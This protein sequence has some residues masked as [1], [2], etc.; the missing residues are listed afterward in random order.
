M[1]AP[2]NS[3]SATG[4]LSGPRDRRT[5][6]LPF[7]H[8][9]RRRATEPSPELADPTRSPT[10]RSGAN[11]WGRRFARYLA[12]AD[13]LAIVL[14]A[15]AVQV[16]RFDGVADVSL[17]ARA[18]FVPAV[19][20]SFTLGVA[21]FI[22]LTVSGSRHRVVI[23]H[24]PNE[25]KAVVRS[26]LWLFGAL[27]IVSYVFQLDLPRSYVAIMMP[28]GA[29]L[30]L[31]SRYLWRRWL[32]G[33]RDFGHFQS[34]VLAVGSVA[35]VCEL[36]TELKDS[37]RAGYR[38][39]GACLTELPDEPVLE[40]AGIPIIGTVDDIKGAVTQVQ[41]DAVAITAAAGLSPATVRSLSWQLEDSDTNLILAPALTD[42]AGTRIHRQPVNGLSLIHVERPTYRGANRW[43]K[44]SFDYVGAA[45]LVL[46]F[47]VPMAVIAGL[48]K[49][50]DRGPVFFLQE[51]VGRDG[52]TFRVVKFRSM[53]IDAEARLA[54]LKAAQTQDAGN[55]VLFKLKDD[56]RITT[57][58]KFLRKFSLD[59]LPQLFNVLGGSMSLVGPRPPLA[60][61]VAQYCSAAHRRL[62]VRPGMT[63]LWQVSGRSSLD[64][65]ETVRL[66]SYYV[67]NWSIT[68][69]LLILWKTMRAV[70]SGG[71]AY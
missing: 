7:T 25:Y 52:K 61:E 42:I 39:V 64:W 16:I 26:T 45:L 43:L 35:S 11:V 17:G 15:A 24:G 32:Q 48:I 30:L 53:V 37:Q 23:G 1:S 67:E 44:K 63:G 66:D 27:A 19:L 29:M 3:E 14:A 10:V 8:P 68:G 36:V 5:A 56:P 58:G 60:S 41:A 49:L 65:D 20:V 4:F 62:L 54:E 13:A 71:G 57:I 38:V 50:T 55:G 34:A 12:V 6:D 22:G 47:A 69:D 46:A 59:E 40:L 2:P 70:V 28:V 18:G 21:W 33:R 51:R 9:D 31:G